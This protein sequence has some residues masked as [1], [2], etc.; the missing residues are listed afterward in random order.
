MPSYERQYRTRAIFSFAL[1]YFFW[2]STYLAIAIGVE[3]LGAELMAGT[4]FL[5][6]GVL[7]LGWCAVTGR[8][9]R[10]SARDTL[11]LAVI[12]I[13]LLSVSNTI[14]GWAEETVPTGLAALL[15]SITPIWFLV[16]ET[17]I[18]RGDRLSRRGI[19]G[20]VLGIAGIVVLLWPKLHATSALGR[21]QLFASVALLG[22]SCTWAIGSVLS[23]RWT[24]AADAFVGSGWEMT[25]AGLINLGVAGLVGDYRSAVW[26]VRGVSAIVYLIIFGSWVGFS[27]YIWLLQNVPMPKVATYAYVNPMVA[28]FLGWLVLHER[29][30]GYILAGSAVIVAGVA[31]VTSAKVRTKRGTL[32]EEPGLPQVEGTG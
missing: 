22:G 5:V 8:K 23:K 3:H 2:G 4:R 13:L 9:V 1:V 32:E 29:V 21:E 20:L 27:A 17:W 24:T 26:T 15:V 6:A 30:D 14:L 25:F 19:V 16:I 12:G 10:V 11:R 7:M 28:V 31:L 18:L